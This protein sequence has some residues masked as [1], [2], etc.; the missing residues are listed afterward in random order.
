MTSV[1]TS[2]VISLTKLYL[3]GRLRDKTP[4]R[5]ADFS[6]F[7][8]KYSVHKEING[9]K[10]GHTSV[11]CDYE[12]GEWFYDQLV[13]WLKKHIPSYALSPKE[14]KKL[15]PN[16]LFDLGEKAAQLVYGRS[17]KLEKRGEI[18]EIMLHG[19]ISDLYKTTTVVSKVYHK[20]ARSDTVKGFD[21]V[22]AVVEGDEIESLW[23]GEAKF[24]KNIDAAIADAV[25]SIESFTESVRL[26]EEFML[27]TNDIDEDDEIGKKVKAILDKSNSLDNITKRICIPVL[28]AY[29]SPIV[30][31]HSVHSEEFK[32]ELIKEVEASIEK[33]NK[34]AVK[35]EIDIHI[36]T[37]SLKQKEE[38][39]K[40]FDT[41]LKG[42]QANV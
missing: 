30:N 32:T 11:Y 19:L 27:I 34:L 12:Q 5:S 24:W 8:L 13:G 25:K 31:K 16:T 6:N 17:A 20:S 28:L 10:R 14:L 36:F 22:H 7:L 1:P 15:D 40:R 38:L 4:M 23:L 21:C 35:V 26:R 37:L 3:L 33:F 9:D 18:G 2:F 39:I 29:E 41:K 42:Y